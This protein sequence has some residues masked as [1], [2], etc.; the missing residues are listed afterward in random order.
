MLLLVTGGAGFIGSCFIRYVLKA[1]PSWKVINLDKLTYAG[2]TENLRDVEEKEGE[3]RY[4]FVH[5]DI[6]DSD[7][8][9]SLLSGRHPLFRKSHRGFKSSVGPVRVIVHFAAE[10]H[11]DR[12]IQDAMPFYRTNVEGTCVLVEI[13]RRYWKGA[14]P[15]DNGSNRFIHIS[16]DEVYGALRSGA[17]PF[18]EEHPLRPNS[19]YAASKAASD[20]LVLSYV[21][22]Y[23]LPAIITRCGN[24]YGPYQYPEKLIPLF[25][26]N[27]MEDKPLPLYGDGLQVR[28]WIHVQD[29]C[30]AILK[31]LEGGKLGNIYNIGSGKERTNLEVARFIVR[32][33]GKPYSLIRSVVDR[34]GHDRRYALDC[35][36]IRANLKWRP[37]YQ[38]EKGLAETIRWYRNRTSWW[39]GLKTKQRNS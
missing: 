2:N 15:S 35:S 17:A 7:L 19:P 38:F 32:S 11:V 8:L 26:T 6:C 24:N 25:I 12:S 30:Q 23:G 34:P 14:D 5:G 9:N 20:L 29:H 4:F 39:K 27:A 13:A 22:T 33:L 21:H 10:S 37:K 16:T 3:K 36:K 28:D 31:V 18:R 1:R